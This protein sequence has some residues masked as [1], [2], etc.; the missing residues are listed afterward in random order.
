MY[1]LMRFIQTKGWAVKH[2]QGVLTYSLNLLSSGSVGVRGALLIPGIGRG[3]MKEEARGSVV[4]TVPEEA[5]VCV[6]A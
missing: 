1:W 2:Q 3:W 5:T 6:T 4:W